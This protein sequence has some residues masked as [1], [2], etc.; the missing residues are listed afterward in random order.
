[1][2][3]TDLSLDEL[4]VDTIRTLSM[5]AVQKAMSGHPGTPMAL[6]PLAYVLFT[7]TMHHNP[8][9]P[10]WPD[11]DRFVLS[12][13]HASMLLYS[14][15]YLSGYD[16]S[17]EDL[18]QFRQ[19]GSRTPGH[20]EYRLVPGVEVTT[21]PLGQGIAH[22]VG[23]ALA[24]RM[25]AARFNRD[26]HQIVD[27]RTFVIAS[28]GDMEEG[29]SG[30]ASSLAGHLGLGRLIS[31]YDQNHISIEG[32]TKI[33]FTEDV[34]ARFEA[35]GWHVQNLGEEI[36]L[37][38]LQAALDAAIEV[39]DR[40]SLIIVRTHIAQGS[41]HKHDTAGAH[42]S[43]LGEDEIK[44]TKEAYGFPS[45]EPFYV[46][47]AALEHFRTATARGVAEQ[48]RWEERWDAYRAAYPEQAAELQRLID[49][50]L[51]AGWDAEVPRYESSGTMTA[52][53]KSSHEVLQWAAAAVPELVGGSADLTPSTL[54]NIEDADNVDTGSYAGRNLHFGIREHAMGA[55]VNGLTLHYLRGYG[56]TFL[57]F[58]DYMRGSIR[59]AALMEIPSIFAFTHDS[60]G[61][62]EDGPTH[63]PIEHLAALRAVPGLSVIRPAGANE[64]ALA[65]RHAIASRDRPSVLVFSRQGIP[66]WDPA[67]I[68]PDAIERG[69]YVL[70][71]S[72]HE[73]ELILMGTGTEVHIC[74]Q[75]VDLLEAEGIATRLVSMPCVDHFA[76]Q[77]RSY[78][79]TVLP[80]SCRARVSLE[81]ASTFGWHR[82]VGDGGE[83]IGMEGFG[84]SAPA[85]AL[86]KHFDLTPERVAAAGRAAV[87]RA[88]AAAG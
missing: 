9:D 18:E 33:A 5:D 25:L 80:P 51:P 4:C 7:R 58:S 83:A 1:M 44:L 49:G 59:L 12:C 35:Y 24:E 14:T 82:W 47:P 61:L 23:L 70:R 55:V 85:G 26:G 74:N 13:G 62:G 36:G 52:T 73:P 87:E 28:D 79:D 31:F 63:Q 19:L 3:T 69:A 6:A 43:P 76:A 64:T 46:P 50:S 40:P 11:R 56:S 53:R 68:P 37:D 78:R 38:R 86:Y 48:A 88:K 81:A 54:T 30:E 75:A 67:A 42:G 66:T 77:D 34:G 71:D 45:L 22:A 57:T 16:L 84:A 17:L 41:P 39:A 15:L 2:S 20:P 10:K 60:I 72:A 29:L 21:G 32:D 8:S 27:H 65:W